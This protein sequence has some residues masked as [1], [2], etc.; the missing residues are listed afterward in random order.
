MKVYT[1]IVL[2]AMAMQ[3]VLGGGGGGITFDNAGSYSPGG[4]ENSA[5]TYTQNGG[6]SG[7]NTP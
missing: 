4:T 5:D 1:T 6:K 7:L 3:V 2:A